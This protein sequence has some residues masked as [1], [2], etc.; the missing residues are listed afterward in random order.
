MVSIADYRLL[1]SL[2]KNA[3]EGLRVLIQLFKEQN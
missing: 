2:G 1:K 3:S